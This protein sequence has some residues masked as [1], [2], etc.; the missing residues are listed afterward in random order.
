VQTSGFRSIREASIRITGRNLEQTLAHIDEMW[1][2]FAPNQPVTRRFLDE[3]F[4]AL[5]R[6]ERRQGQMFT[7]FALAA[8]TVAS[9]GLF[10]LASFSTARRTKEIGLRK[11]LGAGVW[12]IV[13]LFT[14][15]FAVLV[16]IANVVAWPVAYILMRR[17][18][19]GFAYRIE[20][21][22]FAFVASGEPRASAKPVTALR[23]E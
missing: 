23:Y 5:Y 10:G 21:G 18:L 3:D 17:W 8:I 1:L 19:D 14:T 7:L 16:A 22:P 20:L 11:T 13:Q 12:D 4:D 9:I 6:A 15:E 2:R